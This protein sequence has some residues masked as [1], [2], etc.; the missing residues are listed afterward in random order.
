MRDGL[1]LDDL[2]RDFSWVD[3]AAYIRFSRQDSALS[4]VHQN[5]P[6][7]PVTVPTKSTLS[8]IGGRIAEKRAALQGAE[9]EV[10]EHN[11]RNRAAS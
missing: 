2:G 4:F 3:L 1:S 5:P 9:S 7:D 6:V 11:R 10:V 8:S